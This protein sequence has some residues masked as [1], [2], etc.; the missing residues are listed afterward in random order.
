MQN[1]SIRIRLKAFDHKLIDTSTLEIVRQQRELVLKLEDQF[2]FRQE[3]K[4]LQ[5]LY[6]LMLIKMQEISMKLELT[7][8]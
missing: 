7:S 2:R 1:Q 3:K 5:F 6:R 8:A 4:D